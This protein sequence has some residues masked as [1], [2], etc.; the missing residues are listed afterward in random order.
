QLLTSPGESAPKAAA[1][2][3]LVPGPSRRSAFYPTGQ[4]KPITVACGLDVT[5][6]LVADPGSCSINM[7]ACSPTAPASTSSRHPVILPPPHPLTDHARAVAAGLSETACLRHARWY[8]TR[9]ICPAGR[10]P[11]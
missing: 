4:A 3:P 9:P 1:A 8:G 2:A 10:R 6:R 5:S 7:K 11:A